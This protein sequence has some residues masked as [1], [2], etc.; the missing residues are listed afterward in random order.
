M[1]VLRQVAVSG[2]NGVEAG[3]GLHSL[4]HISHNVDDESVLNLVFT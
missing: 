4:Q 1:L 3:C 2:L